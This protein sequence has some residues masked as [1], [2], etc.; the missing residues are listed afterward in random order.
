M[1][2]SVAPPPR[3]TAGSTV[4][5]VLRAVL[6]ADLADSTAFVQRFGDVRAA[7]VLQRLDLQI[8]DLLEFTGGRLI[9]KADGLLAIFERP[10]QAV[11]FAL[12]YQQALRQLSVDEGEP[13]AARVGIHVGELMTWTNTDQDVRAGA[14]PLEVEGLAKP[15]AARLMALALPGQILVSS[16]AQALAQRAQAELGERADRVKWVSHGRYRFK[17]VPAPILVHEVGELGTSPLKQPPSGHKVWRE[18]PLWRRPPVL[19]AELLVMLGVVGFFGWTA[20]RSPP[21]LA[22]QQRDWVVVG[23]LNNFT[24]DTRLDDSLDTALRVSLEQSRY[25]NVV[26][27]LKVRSVLQRMGRSPDATVDRAVASE[28]A[29]RE[30]A[31]AV[32]LPSVAEVGGKLRVSLELVDPSNGVTVF[33]DS[34]DGRGVDSALSSLDALDGR[35][36]EKLGEST[37][38][39][40]EASKPLAEITTSS[41]EA[42]RLYSLA[43]DASFFQGDLA[44]ASRLIEMAIKADP[45]FALA[46]TARA[47]LH[48]AN[49]DLVA[50]RKD[51][52]TANRFRDHLSAR[53]AINLDAGLAE[54]GP[55]QAKVDVW[56]TGA[57]IYPD[58]FSFHYN[59]A[60]SESFYL[61]RFDQAL[62]DLQPAMVSQNPSLKAAV[63]L[64]GFLLVGMEKLP[65][66]REAFERAE[67]LGLREPVRYHAD[68]YAAARQF[69]RARQLAAT[70]R[71]Y[72]L[73]GFDLEA[74]LPQITYPLDEGK[75]NDA[76]ASAEKLSKTPDAPLQA[77]SYRATWLGLRSYAPA[78]SLANEWRK[79]VDDEMPRATQPNGSE[80]VAS[81]FA[82]LYGAASLARAGDPEFARSTIAR[83]EAVAPALGY[84]AI[85]DMLAIARAEL[86]L[87]AKQ[88]ADAVA[89]LRARVNGGELVMV[90]AVLLRAFLQTGELADAR[91]EAEWLTTH[92]GLAYVE[93]NSQNVL[94]PINVLETDLALLSL[95]EI[96]RQ[97]GDA[98]LAQRQLDRFLEAWKNPPPFAAQRVASVRDWI[99][100]QH[101]SK[102]A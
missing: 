57:R 82:A 64:K 44:E 41:I 59:V 66:A 76:L 54:F 8:R 31:R 99:S 17:G 87:Q 95:A 7:S 39:I 4:T 23:D 88:P 50:A 20:L 62:A 61:H 85:D 27:D 11:D 35:L 92:R 36:R 45:Q 89:R 53:E 96:A 38:Q 47:R 72:G 30:G 56:K 77:R 46:Y 32:L 28:I 25:V 21:A 58:N 86:E 2:L 80:A 1:N 67:T 10:I 97:N 15:V 63:F 24:G 78:A 3:S 26:P 51:F 70:Q 75:W 91:R 81:T 55:V 60:Y 40:N 18:L 74:A 73:P 37:S 12:R 49:G 33:A 71:V 69:E 13:I 100:R 90:H 5:P 79:L 22:F 65:E 98:A 16:M 14:K 43:R 9:D 83:L 52:A 94:Q 84:P 101:T 29:M 19:A 34:E 42:L 93:W 102:K 48:M 6:L 68:S